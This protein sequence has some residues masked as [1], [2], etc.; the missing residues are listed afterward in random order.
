[1]VRKFHGARG[2]LVESDVKFCNAASGVSTASSACY[3]DNRIY[4]L[5]NAMNFA[6]GLKSKPNLCEAQGILCAVY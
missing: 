2:F 1:M 5:E 4:C 3:K 6:N